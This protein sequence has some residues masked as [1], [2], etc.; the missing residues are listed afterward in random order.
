[1][2]D[3]GYSRLRRRADII[4]ALAHPTRLLV[5][6]TL[7]EGSRT[8]SELAE[9]VPADMSTVSRHI[10]VLR[11]AGILSCTVEGNRRRYSLKTPCVLNFLSCVE[12]IIEEGA[13]ACA[14]LHVSDRHRG[15]SS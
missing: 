8:V 7:S 9:L 15:S 12:D 5:V 3:S 10:S 6:E 13:E 2:P 4:A 1:M 14:P 11:N